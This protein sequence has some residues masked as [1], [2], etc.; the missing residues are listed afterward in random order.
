M[1]FIETILKTKFF[2]KRSDPAERWTVK[3][4]ANSPMTLQSGGTGNLTSP[5]L[6]SALLLAVTEY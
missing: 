2:G 4:N 5:H 6:I 3:V 1:E